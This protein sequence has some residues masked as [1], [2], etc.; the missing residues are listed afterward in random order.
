MPKLDV[1]GVVSANAGVHVPV[2][3]TVRTLKV[4][5]LVAVT[6]ISALRGIRYVPDVAPSTTIFAEAVKLTPAALD[7]MTV[8]FDPTC[9]VEHAVKPVMVVVPVKSIVAPAAPKISTVELEATDG[10]SDI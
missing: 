7:G 5:V 4:V 2:A 8:F 9:A 1:P 10:M 6:S 3:E